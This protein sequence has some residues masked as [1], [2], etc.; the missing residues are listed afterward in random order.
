MTKGISFTLGIILAIWFSLVFPILFPYLF[1]N[2][3]LD[4]VV[5][6][7]L[8]SASQTICTFLA[9]AF[10]W[11]MTL[12]LNAVV[13]I[14]G[15]VAIAVIYSH[16]SKSPLSAGWVVAGHVV[17]ITMAIAFSEY[18]GARILSWHTATTIITHALLLVVGLHVGAG[19]T[20]VSRSLRS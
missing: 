2:V 7:C 8:E 17:Y 6:G 9:A 4:P 11:G 12:P 13:L 10:L 19:L 20:R 16:A 14:G 3:S 1:I 5:G 15:A 18:E